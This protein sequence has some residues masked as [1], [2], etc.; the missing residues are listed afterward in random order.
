MYKKKSLGQHF[1]RSASYLHA[2]ADAADIKKGETVVEV[3]PG[4]GTL[5]EVLLERGAHVVA[6]EKDSRLIPLLREKFAG[7]IFEVI[8]GDALEFEPTDKK[9]KVVGN[10]PYYISGALFRKFLTAQHQPST[11]VFLVQKEVAERI[12]RSK[13]ESILSLSVKAY[14]TPKYIKTVPAGAFSPP[15][16]VDSAILLVENISRK[17][18]TNTAHEEKFFELIKKAFGQKRKV[19]RNTL[20]DIGPLAAERPEDV[21]L[22]KWLDLSRLS[23][24][25]DRTIR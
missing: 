7:K 6:L 18:F 14:G 2:V 10:I 4:E 12:A 19:L 13:K 24:P 20:G 21:S 17:N 16:K 1:L 8:E 9:Y 25:A 15:P 5:T 11:L 3:G 22:L 23:A